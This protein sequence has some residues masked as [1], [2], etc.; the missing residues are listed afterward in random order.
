MDDAPFRPYASGDL[1]LLNVFALAP[2]AELNRKERYALAY[3][4]YLE[5]MAELVAAGTP[6]NTADAIALT[7][8]ANCSRFP[9]QPSAR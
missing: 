8:R 5:R 1:P 4:A 2:H 3:A 6:D 9:A 7:P